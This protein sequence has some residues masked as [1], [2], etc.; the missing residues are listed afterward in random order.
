MQEVNTGK[1]LSEMTAEVFMGA[2]THAGRPMRAVLISQLA[3][4]AEPGFLEEWSQVADGTPMA[5]GSVDP[6]EGAV[7][8]C[9][10]WRLFRLGVFRPRL[11]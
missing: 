8:L 11:P 3:R 1:D 2:R 9:V 6:E 10:R 7:S 5:F 4:S